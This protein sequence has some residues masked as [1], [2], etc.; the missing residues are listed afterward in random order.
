MFSLNCDFFFLTG[1]D[2][3]YTQKRDK[4]NHSIKPL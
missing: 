3:L 4:K 1:K 2:N